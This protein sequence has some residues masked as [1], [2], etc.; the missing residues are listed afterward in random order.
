MQHSE[1]T[2]MYGYKVALYSNNNHA[3]KHKLSIY[4]MTKVYQENLNCIYPNRPFKP[5]LRPKNNYSDR[6][7]SA[8]FMT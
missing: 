3:A 4:R 5:N 2:I 7:F 8:L 1:S 6:N